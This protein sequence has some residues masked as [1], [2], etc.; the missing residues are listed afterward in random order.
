MKNQKQTIL[1]AGG[2]IGIE[3]AKALREYTDDIRLV[4]RNPKTVNPGDEL[5]SADLLNEPAVQK[6]V[7]GSAVVYLTAGLKYDRTVWK[8]KWPVIMSN[9]IKA[10]VAN[11][12]KLVFFDNVYMYDKEFL[13]HMT[14][15][16]AVNPPSRKGKIRAS[17]ASTLMDA[18][19]KGELKALI[20]RSADFYGPGIN[21]SMLTETV[22]KPMQQGKRATW[23]GPLEYKHS[24]T[25]TPDAAKATAIL[26]NSEEAYNQVWHLPTGANPPTAKEWIETIAAE[27]EVKAK[28]VSLPSWMVKITGV[29]VPVMKEMPEMMYQYNRDYIFDS[30][31]FEKAYGFR[32]TPYS[33]GIKEVVRAEKERQ[34]KK[35][36]SL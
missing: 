26:G 36:S 24:F 20:A 9:V 2:A 15:D 14:E 3:L 13:S 12:A 31:K 34:K 18:T 32:S 22:I 6:A 33:V 29:F 30:S 5:V 7:E 8:K 10:C 1:G 23:L 25:Y 17:I 11:K 21:T 27:L 35:D 4:S 19:K 16:T 28:Y